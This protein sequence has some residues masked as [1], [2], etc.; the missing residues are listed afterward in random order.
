MQSPYITTSIIE[1]AA[2]DLELQHAAVPETVPMNGVASMAADAELSLAH[3]AP[4]SKAGRGV[5]GHSDVRLPL[6][7]YAARQKSLGFFSSLLDRWK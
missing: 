6:E 2:R 7:G 1:E 4:V 3:P 5:N